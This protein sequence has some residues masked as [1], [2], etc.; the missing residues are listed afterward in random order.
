MSLTPPLPRAARHVIASSLLAMTA[1][2]QAE[3]PDPIIIIIGADDGRP[4]PSSDMGLK[5]KQDMTQPP[6]Q[7]MGSEQEE[8]SSPPDMASSPDMRGPATCQPGQEVYCD[9]DTLTLC[10]DPSQQL[11]CASYQ[12]TCGVNPISKAIGCLTPS[13]CESGLSED[14]RYIAWAN[15]LISPDMHRLATMQAQGSIST[16]THK[17]TFDSTSFSLEKLGEAEPL[18]DCEIAPYGGFSN[19]SPTCG[20]TCTGRLGFD[21]TKQLRSPSSGAR[22]KVCNLRGISFNDKTM[23]FAISHAD[24]G[25]WLWMLDLER[26]QWIQD[27]HSLG[28]VYIKFFELKDECLRLWHTREKLTG[29]ILPV[30]PGPKF[31]L[32]DL[33][34]QLFLPRLALDRDEENFMIEAAERVYQG[35]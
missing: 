30:T 14:N 33:R 29:Q 18:L 12:G 31:K 15:E 4:A 28:P 34:N 21:Y 7:D 17:I 25:S 20:L 10:A 6:P 13:P 2:G 8:M 11:D 27:Q 23:N 24:Y 32:W 1:C 3:Q 35:P 26:E 9:G 19:S 5:P 22:T 16:R